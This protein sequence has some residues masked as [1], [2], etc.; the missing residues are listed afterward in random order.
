VSA[1][2][3]H[4]YGLAWYEQT[5]PLVLTRRQFLGGP[6]DAARFGLPGFSEMHALEAVDMDG[7][8]VQD[9][10]TG[11]MYYSRPPGHGVPDQ[12]G[13]PVIYVFK[14][15][16][17]RP[18]AANEAPVTFEPYL[19][20]EQVGVGLQLGVGHLDG[21]SVMDFWRRGQA[22]SA[23]LLGRMRASLRA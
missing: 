7:D 4:R 12:E 20:D 17:D 2:G 21:D 6:E 18:S 15:V 3:A 23:R 19:V 22:G 11:K 13:D 5:A 10:I 14:T 9:L 8:G 1:D 16:R